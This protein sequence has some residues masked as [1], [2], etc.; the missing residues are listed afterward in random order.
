[1]QENDGRRKSKEAQKEIRMLAINHWK[2]TGNM[3]EVSRIFGVSYPAVR[4]WV[5]KF[6]GQG[7]EELKADNRGRP[8]GKELTARQEAVI[9]R[10]ITNRQPEQLK[11]AFG[12]WTRE[13]VGELIERKYGIRRSARQIGR[14]LKE[15][16]FTAQKPV[17]KA[18]EQN[19]Q[20][21]EKWL[22]ETYPAIQAQAKKSGA[23]IYWGDET[24][25]RSHDQRGRTFAPKGQTPVVHKT[26]KR[27]AIHMISAVNNRG[28]LYFMTYHGAIN[29]LKFLRFLKRLVR[30]AK[31][32][33]FLIVDN[34]AVHKTP[35]VEKWVEENSARI[36][37]FYLPAYS[38][39]LNPDEYF[40]QDLKANIVGKIK[41]HS[42]DDLKKGMMKF[43]RKRQRNPKQVQKYFHNKN[44]QYAA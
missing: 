29:S 12:L 19:S 3:L 22:R 15:W 1:M 10:C 35:P 33:V 17:Y 30:S 40:N 20:A 25:I 44:V 4:G 31:G 7:L 9:I 5:K 28:K 39:E 11:L 26:A 8:K 34:L 14:Y 43:L 42:P 6:K 37:L 27:F 38:P 41:M 21:V 2:K 36:Q 24:G 23:M 18:Y 13:N 16:G 32:P